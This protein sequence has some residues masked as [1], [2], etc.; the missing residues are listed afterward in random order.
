MPLSKIKRSRYII[1][2]NEQTIVLSVEGNLR[3]SDA[4]NYNI[5]ESSLCTL[6]SFFPEN[7]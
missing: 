7:H 6:S 5:A 4:G 2:G 3:D 1:Y